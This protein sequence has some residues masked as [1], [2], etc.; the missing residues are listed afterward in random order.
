MTRYR[1]ED[2]ISSYALYKYLL[3]LMN[4]FDEQLTLYNPIPPNAE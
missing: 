1:W 2:R 3:D 4:E